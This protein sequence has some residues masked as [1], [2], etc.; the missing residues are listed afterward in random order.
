SSSGTAT[1]LGTIPNLDDVTMMG[2][3]TNIVVVTNTDGY[4]YDGSSVSQIT[5]PD[6][7]GADWVLYFDGYAVIAEP[8]SGRIYIA[9]PLDPENWNALDF[10]TAEGAPDDILWGVVDHRELF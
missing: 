6:F 3:G 4:V 10:A 2:D 8:N 9:G 1:S 5:D 7:P